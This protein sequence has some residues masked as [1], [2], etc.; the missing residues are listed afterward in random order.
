MIFKAKAEGRCPTCNEDVHIGDMLAY[1]PGSDFTEHYL[2]SEE[3]KIREA[4]KTISV[5]LSRAGSIS[6]FNPPSP[7][8]LD[9]YPFQKAGIH[10]ALTRPPGVGVLFGDEMGLGKS[11]QILGTINSLPETKTALIVCPA[12]LKY[13][14]KKEAETWLTAPHDIQIGNEPSFDSSKQL[15]VQI[16]NY[17]QVGKL[18]ADC[19]F[20]IL[21]LDEMHYL[22]GRG[23]ERRK[24]I[25]VVVE[26]SKRILG[27]SGTPLPNTPEDLWALLKILDPAI[28]HSWD[29]YSKRYC[30]AHQAVRWRGKIPFYYTDTSGAS[31]LEELQEKLR[32]TVMVRRLKKDVL[33]ELPDKIIKTLTL[34]PEG[35][36]AL[37]EKELALFEKYGFTEETTV[38]QMKLA[39]IPFEE[40]SAARK[41]LGLA[42]V[43]LVISHIREALSA[44][45]EKKLIVFAHHKEVL[46][47][48]F[49]ELGEYGP[50]I[51]RGETSPEMRDAAVSRFQGNPYTR[52]FLGSIGAA[53][54]GLTLTASSHVVFAE[55]SWSPK[56]M[57]QAMD[58]A[59]R[60]GQRDVVLVEMLVFDRSL[61][62]NMM[63][64]LVKKGKVADAALDR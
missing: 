39:R 47:Q 59:H 13:N 27:A 21:A 33:Q 40:I 46:S 45:K 14:W 37:I 50:A 32:S 26:R 41:G 2:C 48:L 18:R 34:S 20:D 49:D 61:D 54:V 35:Y 15:H 23:T 9:Y 22:K 19:E 55:V 60:I 5:K 53:G 8:E 44:E 56:D 4:S 63:K 28:W 38:E 12:S 10:F 6:D 16:T 51:I 30:N 29:E 1:T 43:P 24:A 64:K 7:D 62:A 42:K 17:E 58:R 31:N 25:N 36:E 57:A 3:G 52:L 11:I